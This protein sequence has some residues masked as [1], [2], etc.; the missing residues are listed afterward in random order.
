MKRSTARQTRLAEARSK[1][2]E[3]YLRYLEG[4]SLE[5]ICASDDMSTALLAKWF[6]NDYGECW[7]RTNQRDTWVARLL[8]TLREQQL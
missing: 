2:H 7:Q 5:R 8:L 1:T 4:E 6:A 3:F